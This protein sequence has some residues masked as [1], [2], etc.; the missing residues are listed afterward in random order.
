[1]VEAVMKDDI[2]TKLVKDDG[3][4]ALRDLFTAI[5][6]NQSNIIS[7]S[8]VQA[9]LS[10]YKDHPELITVL[11]GLIKAQAD[12]GEISFERFQTLI[13]AM[14]G[15]IAAVASA[16]IAI[17]LAAFS[18]EEDDREVLTDLFTAIDTDQNKK[19]SHSELQAALSKYQDH[20]E[21][22]VVLENLIKA[23]PDGDEITFERFLE[24]FESLP[25]VRGERVRWAETL[26]VVGLLARLLKKGTLF[27]GLGGLKNLKGD[28]LE[29]HIREVSTHF[30]QLL[31]HLLRA[32]IKKLQSG[33]SGESEAE[34][35]I[36]TKF[37]MDGAYLGRFA[38]LDDFYNGP[39]A[40][41]GTPNARI[42][43]GAEKEHKSRSNAKRKFTSN[44]YNI[45]TSPALEWEFVVEPEPGDCSKYPHTPADKELWEATHK[46]GPYKE[47]WRQWKGKVGRNVVKLEDFLFK[48]AAELV[49]AGLQEVEAIC[50]C[51]YTGPMFVLY[52]ASLRGFPLADVEALDGN[53]FETTI[54]TIASGIT[55][56]SKV[57]GI[58]HNRLLFRG[59]GGM[60]LPEQ[61]W[62]EMVECVVTLLVIAVAGKAKSVVEALA[63]HTKESE[64]GLLKSSLKTK[65]I[66]LGE[67]VGLG[68][69]QARAVSEARAEGDAVHFTVALPVSKFEFTEDCVRKGRFME[70]FKSCCGEF[71]VEVRLVKVANKPKDFKGGGMSWSFYN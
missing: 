19:I 23:N 48:V 49:R 66:C 13:L 55:K 42:W 53:K 32:G 70:G 51:L 2:A 67:D 58:P 54:F 10:K 22:I 3:R 12:G 47:Q 56:L 8:E 31:P 15:G 4:E 64:E 7:R 43:E 71:A 14:P 52:N 26:G 36:N 29:K 11:E 65:V 39:E 24:A 6:T 37:A 33:P 40:Q 46:N 61:F 9:A 25:R 41:I 28:E 69:L 50:L 17:K 45:E 62:R 18:F 27:D 35:M 5:G 21:L 30:G 38:S 68:I 34:Q 44:N 60:I 1:M 16:D 57:S 59:L 63:S 20:A